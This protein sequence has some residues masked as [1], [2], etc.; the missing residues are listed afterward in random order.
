MIS[1]LESQNEG[2]IEAKM[3]PYHIECKAF[4]LLR[5]KLAWKLQAM[6][7]QRLACLQQALQTSANEVWMRC[8]QGTVHQ[9][10]DHIDFKVQMGLAR[11]K[12]AKNIQKQ[13]ISYCARP[14]NQ[15]VLALR[16]IE[17]W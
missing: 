3:K 6:A 16:D 13:L 8:R 1:R 17:T 15:T 14:A 10:P 5:V 11:Q 2:E 4:L 12:H 7:V 9:A